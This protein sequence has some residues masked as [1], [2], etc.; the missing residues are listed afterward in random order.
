MTAC[1][2]TSLSANA[3]VTQQ[4]QIGV[5]HLQSA[6]N[7][8]PSSA[9]SSNPASSHVQLLLEEPKATKGFEHASGFGLG[10]SRILK[11]ENSGFRISDVLIRCCTVL[12]FTFSE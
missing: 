4:C 11:P 6:Q 10:K 2:S 5:Q 7:T 8:T 3:D 9:V 1:R 12:L